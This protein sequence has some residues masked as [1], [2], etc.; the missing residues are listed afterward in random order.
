MEYDSFDKAWKG[1][2]NINKTI[3]GLIGLNISEE[4]EKKKMR[5]V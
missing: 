2:K 1:L 3:E 4:V 5:S